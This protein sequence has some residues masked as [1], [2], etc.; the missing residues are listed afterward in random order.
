MITLASRRISDILG[1]C[2]IWTRATI[3]VTFNISVSCLIWIPNTSNILM[4][5]KFLVVG[6]FYG[7]GALRCTNLIFILAAAPTTIHLVA[8]AVNVPAVP[9]SLACRTF[10][11]YSCTSTCSICKFYVAEARAVI[12]NLV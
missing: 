7:T 3:L 9:V 6:N 5:I 2:L 1:S 8:V 10:Q 11:W 12:L 4:R